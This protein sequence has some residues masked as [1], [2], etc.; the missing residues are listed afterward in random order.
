M[1]VKDRRNEEKGGEKLKVKEKKA[2][3]NTYEEHTQADL[4]SHTKLLMAN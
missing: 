4:F 1:K 2:Q 3:K